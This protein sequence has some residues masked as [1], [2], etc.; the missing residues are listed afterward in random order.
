[1]VVNADA[2][3]V[4]LKEA[5]KSFCSNESGIYSVNCAIELAGFGWFQWK[6]LIL[7]GAI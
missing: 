4:N 1:M 5:D 3:Q 2:D 6:V 7:T